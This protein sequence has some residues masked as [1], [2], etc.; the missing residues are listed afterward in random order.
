[1]ILTFLELESLKDQQVNSVLHCTLIQHQK[2]K[3]LS[4]QLSKTIF[5]FDHP[6]FY[7][8]ISYQF[9][10]KSNE[11]T[12]NTNKKSSDVPTLEQNPK[13]GSVQMTINL[14]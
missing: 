12:L 5:C 3:V 9:L 14:L 2:Q 13:R 7:N 6:S 8:L 1:M 11:P 10:N 4:H